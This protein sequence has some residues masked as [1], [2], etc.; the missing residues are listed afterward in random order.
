MTMFLPDNSEQ[1]K[2][3]VIDK[4]RTYCDSNI[5][6]MNYD[7]FSGW[8]HNFDCKI[9]EYIAL[10]ILD[11]L[12]VRSKEMAISSY[13]RLLCSAVRQHL[14][15]HT[16]IEVGTISEWKKKLK[17]G[18]LN[19]NLRFAS[20]RLE[21]DDGESGSVIYRMLSDIFDTNRYSYSRNRNNAEVI[22]LIDDFIGSGDQFSTFADQFS[23]NEKLESAH[24]IY[25]PLIAFEVGVSRIQAE[26]PKLHILPT[27]YIL[28]SDSLFF[29]SESQLFKSDPRNTISD[30]K[31]FL[32][33]MHQKYAPA[34]PSWYGRDDASLL[35]AFEWGCPNQVL[36]ILYMDRSPTKGSWNKLFN[37]RA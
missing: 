30:V 12:I 27:E 36:S 2:Q 5:W 14:L 35:L 23:L 7:K 34:M 26:F 31:A 21:N 28:K 6:P 4:I 32:G 10:Q 29:G 37:R 3:V 11:N 19:N 1:F 15:K 20:V 9:E 16:T 25:C 17:D 18:S 24:I 8:L 22:I 33:G 13:E